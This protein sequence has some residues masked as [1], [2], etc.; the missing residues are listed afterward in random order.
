MRRQRCYLA[1]SKSWTPGVIF[2]DCQC[3]KLSG[4]ASRYT[5][6]PGPKCFLSAVIQKGLISHLIS[7]SLL[8]SFPS[9]FSS[10]LL[11]LPSFFFFPPSLFSFFLFY[12]HFT[13][14]LL[15]ILFLSSSM[16]VYHS[17]SVITIFVP[18]M[19]PAIHSI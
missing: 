19:T 14:E 9:L 5:S 17:N 12:L 2:A 3:T 4:E 15:Q 8:P 13:N 11:F 1:H 6:L 10:F 16:L 18:T 7:P